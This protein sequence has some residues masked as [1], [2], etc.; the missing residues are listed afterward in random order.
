[1]PHQNR[2]SSGFSRSTCMCAALL[3]LGVAGAAFAGGATPYVQV[4]AT[5]IE[6]NVMV[7]EGGAGPR[8]GGPR[9]CPPMVETHSSLNF[10]ATI[11]ANV[12]VVGGVVDGEITAAV[13]TLDPSHFPIT[14]RTMEMV[15]ATRTTTEQI[16]CEW[17]ITIYQGDVS[18]GA[19]VVGSFQSDDTGMLPPIT[20][21][22]SFDPEAVKV[23]V[24]VDPSDPEQIVV[25]N[26]GSNKFSIG[27]QIFHHAPAAAPCCGGSN[28]APCCP[29]GD[30]PVLCDEIVGAN[31]A[32]PTVDLDGLNHGTENYLFITSD[33]GGPA[34][35]PCWL[36]L[37]QG[38]WNIRTTYEP[39]QCP[40]F[41]ACCDPNTGGCTLTQ[42]LDCTS[43]GRNWQ[44]EGT[45]CV[46]NLCPQ[47][48]G[49]C[50][51]PDGSCEDDVTFLNCQGGFYEF[52]VDTLCADVNPPFGC[53]LPTG[54]C[55][56]P[57]S[58]CLLFQDTVSCAALGG[59]FLGVGTGCP[60]GACDGACCFGTD[61][62]LD[63]DD[64]FTCVVIMGGTYQGVGTL[65]VS[66]TECPTAPCCLANGTCVEAQTP[67][68]CAALNG[69]YFDGFADCAAANCPQPLG[70]CCYPTGFCLDDKSE[71]ECTA[72][73]GA[74]WPGD[75]T[76]CP[77]DCPEGCPVGTDLGNLN[78]DL[79]I[80]GGDI[81]GFSDCLI[82]V[83]PGPSVTCAC[84][85]FDALNGV[86]MAD[87]APFVAALLAA[88]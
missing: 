75:G 69:T 24:T 41:G 36:L 85:D 46:P 67:A 15:Y 45:S 14:M 13:Y 4:E 12:G 88:P 51:K 10:D 50:C 20:L 62:C 57:S 1:M 54:A 53:P 5:P 78:G 40:D 11:P 79:S 26:D 35:I 61:V 55:C 34:W 82:G 77:D 3:L 87:L 39:F 72:V 16:T 65:C 30:P 42:E 47:P 58:G 48:M 32:H 56:S 31:D 73:P 64:E 33:C 84:G 19:S 52:H 2:T 70:A 29:A 59:T 66:P 23:T 63:G 21:G 68:E 17:A 25:Q 9:E 60:E 43:I 80:D 49:A 18:T 44:G 71:S 28:P 83:Y 74:I 81:Q 7:G 86:D 8:D 27:W 76:I 6:M 22:P 37:I 38:D